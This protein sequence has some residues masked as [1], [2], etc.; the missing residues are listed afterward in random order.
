MTAYVVDASVARAAG[1][2]RPGAGPPSPGCVAALDAI[3]ECGDAVVLSGALKAEWDTHARSYA[4]KWLV[5]QVSRR[6]FVVVREPWP[7]ETEHRAV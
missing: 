5:D 6:G 7:R 1:V 2:G 3:A 4:R